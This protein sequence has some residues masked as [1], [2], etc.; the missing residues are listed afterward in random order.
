MRRILT[1]AF[2]ATT[3]LL[4]SCSNPE[5][6]EMVAI[7]DSSYSGVQKYEAELMS[8]DTAVI[9]KMVRYNTTAL[10]SIQNNFK[11]TATKQQ[12][13]FISDINAVRRSFNKLN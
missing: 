4:T 7:I 11:D 12:S 3:M 9:G 1:V 13:I 2:A 5:I 6:E 8:I 10:S